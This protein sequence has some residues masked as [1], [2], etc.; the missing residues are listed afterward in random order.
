MKQVLFLFALLIGMVSQTLASGTLLLRQPTVSNDH[1]V[2]VYANDLWIVERDGGE[3]RRL[4]SNE[5][6]EMLPHFS[7]DGRHIAFTGQYDGNTDVYLIPAEGGQPQR[8]T[9]HPGADQVAG[10]TPD[11]EH[12]LFVSGREGV[13]TRESKFFKIHKDGGMPEALPIPRA[14]SGQIS[15]DG[16]YI[17]YQEVGFVDPE[18]RNYRAGQANPIW[19][20]DLNDFSLIATPQTDNE[21]HMKPVWLNNVVYFISERDYAANIWSFNP[22][23]QVLKQETFHADY[24][25]K[26]LNGGGG[27]IVYEQAARLHLLNPATGQITTPEINVRGDFNWARPRWQDVSATALQ[28]ASLSPTGQRALFEYRGEVY[29]VPKEKGDWRNITNSP[30]AADRFPAWSPDGQQIAWF[31]DAS[32]EYQLFIGDQHGMNAPKVINLPE[33]TFF[34]RPAWS[35]DG[36]FIAYTDTHYNLWYVDVNSGRALKVDTDRFAHPN[37]SLNPVWSP[38]SKWLAYARL[39]DNQFKAIFLYNIET[40]QRIQLTDGMADAITPVW[41]AEGKYLY[42]LASTDYGLST[43]WL[44]MSSYNYPVTRALYVVVLSKDGASPFL[45]LSDEEKAAEAEE[46]KDEKKDTSVVVRIDADGIQQR[47]VA[48]DIPAKNY[49]GLLEGPANYLF[50]FE[51]IQGQ[52]GVTMHRYNFK[53][54]KSESWLSPVQAASVSHDR[55]QLLYRSGSGWGIVGTSEGPKK[56]GDGKLEA[57]TGMKMRIEPKEEWQQMFKEGWRLQRDF[58]YVDNVHGAPWN[59]VY[60]WYR[61]W[62]DHVRHRTD[63]NYVIE[64]MGGEV[65]IGHS[66]TFGGDMPSIDLVPVGLLGAD[67]AIENGHYRFKKIYNGESWNPGLQAPLAQPG[68]AVNEGE[69]LLAV[70]GVQV[71]VNEN[72]YKYFENTSGKQV[73]LRV[74]NRPG[75][76]GS[77]EVIVVPVANENQLRLMDWVEGNRRKVDELSE[78]QLAYVYVPNTSQLGY[79]FFNRYY[80]AQQHKRGAVIDERNNGGGSAADYMVDI[81]ARRLHGYFNSKAGDRRPFTTPM[82]GLWGP[83]VMIINERAG[84]GGDL[85]PYMFRKMEIGPMVGTTTWGGLVGIWDTPPFIDGGVMMAPRGGFFDTDG[86]WAVEAEGVAPDIKVLQTPADV[87]R[88]RD[89]QLERSVQEALKLLETEAI[90]LKPEPAPPVRYRRPEPRN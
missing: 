89:P 48:V 16:K 86:N 47:I 87:I 33:P 39:L 54:R 27:M 75:I 21:R 62:V 41:D 50:Y 5:G 26:N 13:P 43:G 45:P 59:D 51:A 38:D 17:A 53:D 46:K 15:Q 1:I 24:D 12:I 74:N 73:K 77:R 79:V 55:K 70:N 25:V 30:G 20:V 88:G 76:Q 81:M 60:N 66:Y 37:R 2:F 19:I 78:G 84:S 56:P 10:W 9:W 61:P 6:A 64:I 58:L 67:F 82:A 34:F 52:P 69:Y 42:F 90:E 83:K 35:P 80:F 49:T 23:T 65:A 85:L 44:D 4:T 8:L 29:T 3:A 32:G 18:W 22:A 28:N 57:L 72:L 31:S 14:V 11:G 7:P 36:K 71:D 40:G 68:A 63:L